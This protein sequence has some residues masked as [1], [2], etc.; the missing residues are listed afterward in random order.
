MHK[1]GYRN[2]VGSKKGKEEGE[3]KVGKREIEKQ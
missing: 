3:R 2:M 1:N